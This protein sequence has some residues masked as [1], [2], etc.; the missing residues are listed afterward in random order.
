MPNAPHYDQTIDLPTPLTSL[1]GR[2][3]EIAAIIARLRREDVRLLTLTGPGGVG[4]TRLAIA[5]AGQMRSDFP[6]GVWFVGLAPLADPALVASAIAQVLGVREASEEPIM[7]RLAAFMRDRR[8][9]VV[10]DNFEHVVEAAPLIVEL[11]AACPRLSVLATSRMRLRLTAE[12]EHAV[13]PLVL[14]D[15]GT[16]AIADV[17]AAEAVRLFVD[18][19]QAVWADFALGDENAAAVAAICRRLDGLPLAIELAAARVKVLPPAALLTRLERRLPLLT[20]GGRDLPARQR[21]MRDAIAWSYDLLDPTEQTLFRRLAIFVGK[22]ALEAAEAV[23]AAEDEPAR[24][25]LAGIASLVD[26][27]L[28]RRTDGPRGAP[29]YLMLETVRE[30]AL[31]QLAA[32]GESEALGRRHARYFADLAE[33]LGP[34]VDGSD[35]RAAVA[36]LD[37]DEANL[38]AA[39]GWAIAH[40]ERAQA[41]RLIWALWSYWF[42]RGHFREGIAW[43]AGAL[44]LPGEAPLHLRILA[45]DIMAN[46]YS[47]SGQFE[48]AAATAQALRELAQREGDAIGEALALFQLSFVARHER[49]HDA[50]VDRSEEAL[51]RFRAL[52]CKRWLPW[53]AQR[54]GIERMGRGDHDRAARLFREAINLFLEMG[55]EGGTAMALCNLGLALHGEG[56][57][58]GAELLLRAVLKREAALERVW[59]ITDVLL[60][61]ADVALTRGQARRAALLLGATEALRQQG[62]YARHGWARDTYDRVLAGARAVLGE[63]HVN[64]LWQ[65]GRGL[66]WPEAVDAALAETHERALRPATPDR[67]DPADSG[68]TRREREV[69]RLVAAGHSNRAIAEILSISAKT[70]ANHVSSILAKLGVETRTAAATQAVRDGLV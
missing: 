50:A 34:L 5:V 16:P 6:D 62:D 19:A 20:G 63:D 57:V 14:A 17:A 27:S 13:P 29:R 69:L 68:L 23:C 49:D 51:A 54:A 60:G 28:L 24:D 30:F 44:A 70:A 37:V 64:A 7:A 42:T 56:D 38:R 39:I 36:S 26:K 33:C 9:L 52:R 45:L 48:R 40:Q 47:L 31:E 53:A 2:E 10:L 66:T 18:R 58:A 12:R 59:E 67:V 1:I 22:F 32:G 46:M 15:D 8:A 61:L 55:N 65:H 11:L 25:V 35:Q 3:E 4:K 21:T 43:T 41:L